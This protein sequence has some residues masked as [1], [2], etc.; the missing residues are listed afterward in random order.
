MQV[1]DALI[2]FRR[3]EEQANPFF[4]STLQVN[5]IQPLA[6]LPQDGPVPAD[7]LSGTDQITSNASFRLTRQNIANSV[8]RDLEKHEKDGALIEQLKA[9]EQSHRPDPAARRGLV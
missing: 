1:S 8:V 3:V 7:F 6:A 5:F 9:F 2:L 4:R